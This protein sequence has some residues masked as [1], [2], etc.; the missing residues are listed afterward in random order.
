MNMRKAAQPPGG[1]D[2]S[3]P[4]RWRD[5]WLHHHGCGV[6]W[7]GCVVWMDSGRHEL[8]VCKKRYK[9]NLK[10]RLTVLLSDPPTHAPY[11]F[12]WPS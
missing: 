12:S 7:I 10:M 3:N 1:V 8:I 9:N 11:L 2:S 5:G 4:C 6:Y